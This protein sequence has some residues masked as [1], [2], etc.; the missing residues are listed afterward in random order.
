MSDAADHEFS[1]D[2]LFVR[3]TP[4]APKRIK[5][6]NKTRKSEPARSSKDDEYAE[7]LG[8]TESQYVPIHLSSPSYSVLEI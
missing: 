4:P 8:R 5:K 6:N 2:G 7:D 1:E 3:N